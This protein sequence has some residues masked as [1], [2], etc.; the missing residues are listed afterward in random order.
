VPVELDLNLGPPPG[1]QVEAAAYYIAS[2]A[3]ANAAKHAQASVIDVRVQGADSAL[4]L[5]ICDDGIGGADPS[6]GSGIIGLKDR[7]EAL[8]GAISVPSPPRH[9]TARSGERP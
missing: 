3:F 4:T 9:R 6:R 5:S 7:V 8:G 1:Q 2:E